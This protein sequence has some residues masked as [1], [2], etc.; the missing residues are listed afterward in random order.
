MPASYRRFLLD[1]GGGSLF[2]Y[3]LIAAVFALAMLAATSLVGT[4]AAEPT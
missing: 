4:E 1:D 2:D 3:A